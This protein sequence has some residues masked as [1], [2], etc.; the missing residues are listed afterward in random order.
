MKPNADGTCTVHFNC[1]KDAI[2]NLDSAGR[3]YNYMIR[4]YG[5][6]KIVKSGEWDPIKDTVEVKK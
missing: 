1:G 3:D 6:S 2:N 4:T 5:A